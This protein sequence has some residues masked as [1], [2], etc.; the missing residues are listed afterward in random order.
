M[1][2][3]LFTLNIDGAEFG[4]SSNVTYDTGSDRYVSEV[5]IRNTNGALVMSGKLSRPIRIANATTA[6]IEVTMDF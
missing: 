5:A 2:K 1:Y 4:D 6:T 3:T